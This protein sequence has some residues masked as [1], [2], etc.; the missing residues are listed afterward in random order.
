MRETIRYKLDWD[1]VGVT[2]IGDPHIDAPSHNRDML[3]ADLER[4]KSYGD[5]IVVM[6]DVW[7]FILPSDV[8]RFTGGKYAERVDDIIGR[9]VDTAYAVFAPYADNIDVMLLGNHET[10][11][12]KRHHVD[13]LRMLVREL[14]RDKTRGRLPNSKIA[15]GGYTCWL[16]L[17]F[18]RHTNSVSNFVWTHHGAGGGAPVTKGMIDANRIKV[19]R[20]ADAYVIAHKHT[21]IH[22]R[23][24]FEYCD[25]YGYRRIV[26]RD[27]IVC[28]GYSGQESNED[29]DEDGYRLDWSEE[30]FYG[31]EGQGSARIVFSPRK[32]QR[33]GAV[34][35]D[36]HR[37]V[38]MESMS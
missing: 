34:R 31:L 36:V 15:H 13:P 1:P 29:Y 19:A 10:A 4:A 3:V 26:E 38:M 6:G 11:V 7:S 24:R 21:H 20:H 25:P 5:S 17:Q 27:Y 9:A 32:R 14:N 23:D 2:F 33:D 28:G 8:K 18:H 12:L 37:S 16:Q 35:F 30:T 22:D